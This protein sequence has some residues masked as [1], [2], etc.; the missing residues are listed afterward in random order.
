M[1][2]S[3]SNWESELI[4]KSLTWTS[5]TDSTRRHRSSPNSAPLASLTSPNA[6]LSTLCPTR[7]IHF[8]HLVMAFRWLWFRARAHL[9][10]PSARWRVKTRA[11][12]TW[13]YRFTNGGVGPTG[14]TRHF[15]SM[16]LMGTRRKGGRKFLIE[17]LKKTC[18]VEEASWESPKVGVKEMKKKRSASWESPEVEVMK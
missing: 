6:S 5:T 7:S 9:M 2:D 11:W 13:C 14:G 10:G 18:W 15:S 17:S 3:M 1:T 8:H 4:L 12:P 16:T